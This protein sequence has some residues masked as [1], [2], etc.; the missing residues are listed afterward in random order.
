MSARS[1][2]DRYPRPARLA[3]RPARTAAR[4]RAH[5]HTHVYIFINACV[6]GRASN[7]CFSV[8][9]SRDTCIRVRTCRR[10]HEG[11]RA[12]FLCGTLERPH[13]GISRVPVYYARKLISAQRKVR[14]RPFKAR[15]HPGLLK[16][17]AAILSLREETS[18]SSE[19]SNISS[20]D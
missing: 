8:Y 11:S 7:I 4:G 18:R 20:N 3:S 15:A 16:T 5:T 2:S 6:C 12:H 13:H 10:A 1:S 17:P 9:A 14:R 19:R